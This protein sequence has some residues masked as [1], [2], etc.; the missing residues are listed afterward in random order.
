MQRLPANGVKRKN[1]SMASTQ[2]YRPTSTAHRLATCPASLQNSLSYGRNYL[3]GE[4]AITKCGGGPFRSCSFLNMDYGVSVLGGPLLLTKVSWAASKFKA[5]SYYSVHPLI[6]S[7][8]HKA[9]KRFGPWPIFTQMADTVWQRLLK[10]H[11]SKCKF[12]PTYMNGNE[13]GQILK[14][15]CRARKQH[16]A[17]TEQALQPLKYVL[18]F[19]TTT[20]LVPF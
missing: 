18:Y 16:M 19:I 4:N 2:L 5:A 13:T 8:T 6:L 14:T 17:L 3:V 1:L 9:S 10:L 20:H 15:E 12:V 11:S 7:A